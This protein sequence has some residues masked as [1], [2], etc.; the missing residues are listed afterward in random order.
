[1]FNYYQLAHRVLDGEEY[2][3]ETK[4]GREGKKI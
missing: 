4:T 3:G 1:M 2:V